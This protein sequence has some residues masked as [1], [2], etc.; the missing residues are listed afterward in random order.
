MKAL[1]PAD[2]RAELERFGGGKALNLHALV[3][4]GRRVPAWAVIGTDAF[5]HF[6]A[7]AG[8]MAEIERAMAGDDP[9]QRRLLREW[10][11]AAAVDRTVFEVIAEA[12]E[13]A[14]GE[15]VAVRSS[16]TEEDS[17]SNSFAGQFDSF[18]DLR[19][20]DSV[21]DHVKLCWASTFSERAATYRRQRELGSASTAMAVIVQQLIAAEKSGVT[22]TVNPTNG[23]RR[24]LVLSATTGLGQALVDG[25]GDAD[26]IVLDRASG[27]RRRVELADEDGDLCLDDQEVATLWQAGTEV[28]EQFGSPQDIEW[29]F[30]D[31]Q[32]WLLQ[33]RAITT[34]GEAPP[35]KP[36]GQLRI[37]DNS[38]VVESF[39][40]V[41][42]PLTFT[43]ARH[44]YHSVYRWYSKS[45]MVPESLLLEMDEWQ[46]N[47][48]AYFNGRVYYNLLN[49]YRM[50]HLLPFPSMKRQM[51]ELAMGVDESVSEELARDSRP[52]RHRS[53]ATER[54]L[55]LVVSA[56][57]AWRYLRSR[58]DVRKF[59][60][61]FGEQFVAIDAVDFES[62]SAEEL[63]EQV[64]ILDR[65]VMPTWGP[66]VALEA[67]ILTSL[68]FL[69]GLTQRWLPD[70]PRWFYWNVGKPKDGV[71]SAEPARAMIVLANAALAEPEVEAIVREGEVGTVYPRLTAAGKSEFLATVDDYVA[72]Y[73][74]RSVDE[75]KL[76]EPSMRDD[77]G[78]FF[79]LLRSS[80]VAPSMPVAGAGGEAE[81]H[82]ADAYLDAN[83]GRVR[84]FVYEIFRRKSQNALA[85]REKV[86]FCRSRGF[87]LVRRMARALDRELVA[88]GVLEQE[89]DIFH[90]RLEELRGAF[91]GTISHQEWRPLIAL[92]KRRKLVDEG[93]DAPPRFI[94]RGPVYWYG[95]LDL[96]GWYDGPPEPTGEI[97]GDLQGVGCCPGRVIGEARVSDAPVEV[98]GEVLVAYRT[99]PGWI[100]A[101]PSVSALLV[102]RGSPLT[103]VAVVARELG[104]PT[105]V[106]IKNL[107]ASVR[108]GMLL[109]VDG[110][111]GTVRVLLER[112]DDE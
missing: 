25:S 15:A 78:V 54:R 43:F 55:R 44:V 71:E 28:E 96:A 11:A 61:R 37:W 48:L 65:E 70:A 50:Q 47:R 16:G 41:T 24:E 9:E 49:W 31:G 95:N 101:L 97:E 21:V 74:Y 5:A 26:T 30:A 57:F 13:R 82:D 10:I 19:G 88:T 94:T 60:D 89:G 4:G 14:G 111:A 100:A 102:E 17:S 68:G 80:L 39:G 64:L 32:L 51:M 29:A 3:A 6:A 103:H 90:L 67:I 20:I 87:G 52:L 7:G 108:T 93:L 53:R 83:L 77:V 56:V 107:T 27:E 76:E 40:G 35:P 73:G 81:A 59:I 72:R 34:V 8:L 91:E 84:R 109:D 106:Q 36:E 86:R 75:L 58:R 105:V 69:F 79:T 2:P 92:R 98:D 23:S 42:S 66:I 46:A 62:M 104:V 12:Y 85:A 110:S 38:N 112:S 99:D 45:L 63:Y 18:L 22:F 33:S 1:G